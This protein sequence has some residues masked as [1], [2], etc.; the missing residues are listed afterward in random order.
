M[1]KLAALLA[2]LLFLIFALTVAYAEGVSVSSDTGDRVSLFD[3]IKIDSE[4]KGNVI[5]VLGN[6]EVNKP[7]DGQV[8]VVFGDVTINGN[9][10]GQIVT[11]FGNTR[12]TSGAVV[13]KDL[14]TLGSIERENGSKVL[15]QEVRIFGEYMNIDIGAL[16]YLRLA[17]MLLFT[18]AVL[19]IG[20]LVLALSRKKYEEITASIEK[21]IGKKL[22]LG[23]LAY[24]G[25][26]ILLVLLIITLVAP[27]LYIVLLVMAA[28]VASIYLGRTILK[29]FSPKNSIYMEFITGLIS[30]T[31]IKLLLIFLVP[32]ENIILSSALLAIFGIFINSIGLGGLAENKLVKK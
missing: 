3:D 28:V 20:L 31:L 16:L 27:V 4:V 7:V 14:I 25:A 21:N 29:T 26:S 1:K 2:V 17:I 6:V 9:V 19:V 5:S 11:V 15:G 12:L 32:Q 30:I 23:F 24:M 10:S 8:V 13:Q 22:L 18:L